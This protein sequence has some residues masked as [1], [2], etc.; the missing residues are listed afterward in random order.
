MPKPL[1]ES[2]INQYARHPRPTPASTQLVK[3]GKKAAQAWA[4]MASP[5]S[6]DGCLQ[7]SKMDEQQGSGAISVTRRSSELRICFCST[8]EAF[9]VHPARPTPSVAGLKF[10][11][12][13]SCHRDANKSCQGAEAC[14]KKRYSVRL[15]ASVI[16]K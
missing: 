5:A 16:N 10:K 4:L 8:C 13:I 9:T 2:P 15:N 11:Y 12:Y 7:E 6:I 1:P 14:C 3:Q